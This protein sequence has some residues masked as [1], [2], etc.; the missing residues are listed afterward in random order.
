MNRYRTPIERR[1]DTVNRS[2]TGNRIEVREPAESYSLEAALKLFKSV[3]ADGKRAAKK[4]RAFQST[5]ERARIKATAI[6]HRASKH[7]TPTGRDPLTPRYSGQRSKKR[8][9][10]NPA[11]TKRTSA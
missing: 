9:P 11:F 1:F 10:V 3:L 4:A 2:F 5:R 6:Q 8:I 7:G